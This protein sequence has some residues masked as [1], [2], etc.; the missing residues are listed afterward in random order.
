[1]LDSAVIVTNAIL[2]FAQTHG[3]NM[4]AAIDG[5]VA[6][7]FRGGKV[8]AFGNGGSAADAQH[9]CGELVGWFRDKERPGIAA[10][11]LGSCVSTLTAIANDTDYDNVFARQVEALAM[12]NDVLIGISTSGTSENVIRALEAG[13]HKGCFCIGLSSGDGADMKAFCHVMLN[14]PSKDTPS[15]QQ[16][17]EFA[18][19]YLCG[20][21]ERIFFEQDSNLNV[22][23]KTRLPFA[24]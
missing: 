19:H 9:L 4:Q 12:P 11:D 23:G 2:E 15:I 3:K 13:E 7:L 6:R 17:H 20:E 24:T 21:V 14:A 1:M 16:V 5:I 8:I 22:D 10:I 18:Y